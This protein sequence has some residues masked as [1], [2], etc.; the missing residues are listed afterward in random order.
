MRRNPF[1]SRQYTQL[2][3][4]LFLM[5]VVS[6]NT[7]AQ[8]IVGGSNVNEGKYPFMV[9]LVDAEEDFLYKAIECG[10]TVIGERWVMTAAH[11]LTDY[12]QNGQI[13]SIKNPS[14]IEVLIG[15]YNLQAPAQGYRRLKVE[16]IYIHPQYRRVPFEINGYEGSIPDNDVALLR[17][18]EDVLVPPVA[19]PDINDGSWE[20]DGLPV[21]VMGWGMEDPDTRIRS[22]S[23]K[24]AEIKLIDRQVCRDY[25]D[26]YDELV[27]TS[28][29]CAGLYDPKQSP[30]GGAQGDSGGP[31]V[32]QTNDGWLQ[33]GIMSWGLS[34]TSYQKPGVFQK[35]S[36]HL[37][38]IKEILGVTGIHDQRLGQEVAVTR[39]DNMIRLK[40]SIEIGPSN[41]MVYDMYGRL[42]KSEKGDIF[43]NQPFE[44]DIPP[45]NQQ[46]IIYLQSDMGIVT[47][48]R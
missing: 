22:R 14:E 40:S 46:I 18:S 34:Y 48:I 20:I 35:I 19:L 16:E 28:M 45:T 12:D 4:L 44:V 23:L 42:V 13:S 36:P 38:W 3:G 5:I 9:G 24:E 32:F 43:E 1:M 47:A 17:L 27:L 31:L 30:T 26:F 41:I 10:A 39:F 29:L 33:L 37:V 15:T 11:C 8:G 7:S 21:R 2:F 25:D 6:L